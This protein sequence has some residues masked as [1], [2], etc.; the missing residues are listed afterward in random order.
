MSLYAYCLSD[1]VTALALET[2]R[3]VAGATPILI[4]H[5]GLAAVVSD[6]ENDAVSVT[7]ENVLAHE[8]VVQQVLAQTTPL[9]FRFGTLA[10]EARLRN[11]LATQKSALC[12]QLARVRGC[13]EM[14]VKVIRGTEAFESESTA[15]DSTTREEH[16]VAADLSGGAGTIY[17]HKKRREMMGDELLKERAEEIAGWLAERL[18]S[19]VRE[20]VVSVRP[21][22]ML[23][24]AAAYL[25]EVARL[26]EYRERLR[27]ARDERREIHFLTSGPWP[28][29]S[30]SDLSS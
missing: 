18:A 13:V 11:Y 24:V 15:Q 23:I 28:P 2:I 14:S 30:F 26:E 17:L 8:R 12:T 3:G 4:E 29:Y 16:Q 5:E 7:R 19:T 25:V 1:E 22:E 6:Y 9:P 20:S 10:S 27:R 21:K